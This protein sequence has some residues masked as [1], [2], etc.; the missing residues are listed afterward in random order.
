MFVGGVYWM[1]GVRLVAEN[2]NGPARCVMR[3]AGYVRGLQGSR[4]DWTSV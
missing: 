1:G 3:D 2:E 4:L